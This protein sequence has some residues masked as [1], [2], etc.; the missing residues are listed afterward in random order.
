MDPQPSPAA[1]DATIIRDARGRALEVKRWSIREARRFT[2]AMGRAA[3]IDRWF[4]EA[5]VA[6]QVRA[7]DG[8]P[9]LMPQTADQAD[10]LVERLGAEGL[11][12]AANWLN[13]QPAADPKEELKRVGESQGTP[14]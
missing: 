8:V 5:V 3:D 11:E 2:R 4:G 6:A 14:T 7:I 12:A 9:V 1:G 13:E 10:D